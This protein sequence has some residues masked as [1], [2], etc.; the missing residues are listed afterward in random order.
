MIA[1]P[2][3]AAVETY[4]LDPD[5]TYVAWRI[6]HL[7]FSHQ[8]GKWMAQGSLQLDKEHP[9]NDKINAT[10]NVAS[11]ITGNAKLDEHL[12]GPQFFD[13]AQFPTATFVS[14]KVD[15]TG[16]KSASVKGMLT[17]HGIS[18]PVTLNVTFNSAAKNPITNKMTVG[19]SATTRIKRSDF[20]MTTLLPLLGDDVM[21]NIEA[22]AFKQ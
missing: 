7:G 3:F 2:A 9:V 11:M 8:T 21:L 13:V 22:E 5:H 14:S 19:F 17:L 18:K 20:G 1:L 16:S 6:S 12:K 10:I 15:V 4:T